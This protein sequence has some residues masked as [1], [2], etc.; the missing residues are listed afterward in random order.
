[1]L[2]ESAQKDQSIRKSWSSKAS[3][4]QPWNDFTKIP[5]EHIGR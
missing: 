2:A 4:L 1:M 3:P 5:S